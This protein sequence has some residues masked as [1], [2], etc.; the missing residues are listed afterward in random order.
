M[1]PKKHFHGREDLECCL[2]P[3]GLPTSIC[4]FS[5]DPSCFTV[6]LE[7]Y[8]LFSFREVSSCLQLDKHFWHHK[9]WILTKNTLHN[10]LSHHHPT[11]SPSTVAE[12]QAKAEKGKYFQLPLE[13]VHKFNVLWSDGVVEW[14]YFHLDGFFNFRHH[15]ESNLKVVRRP[16]WA[17]SEMKKNRPTQNSF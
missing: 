15:C 10:Q 1:A 12:C 8:F 7:K 3:P 11:P 6:C 14:F 16:A 5:F 4:S 9:Q 13:K 17:Q 2:G